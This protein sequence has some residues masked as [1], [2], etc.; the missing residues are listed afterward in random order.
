[1]RLTYRLLGTGG[2]A[3]MLAAGLTVAGPTPAYAADCGGSPGFTNISDS[4]KGRPVNGTAVANN[5]GHAAHFA[6]HVGTINDQTMGW[7]YM[8]SG[9]GSHIKT[10]VWMDVTFNDRQSWVQCGP[11]GR[12][13]EGTKTSAAFPTSPS[14]N[15]KFRACAS[16]SGRGCNIQCLN[17][18]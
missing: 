1:M 16:I 11:F 18:W 8:S 17:W 2:S 7:A 12:W 4:L 15:V 3:L 10:E 5:D 6:L 14:P 13:G 9:A